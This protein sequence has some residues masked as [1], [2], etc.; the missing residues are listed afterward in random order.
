MRRATTWTLAAAVAVAVIGIAIHAL[1]TE[2]PYGQ[3]LGVPVFK[4]IVPLAPGHTGCE[5]PVALAEDTQRVEFNPGTPHGEPGPAIDVTLRAAGTPRVLARGRLAGGFDPRLPQF[6]SVAPAVAQNTVVDV[7]FRNAA[8]RGTALL[9]GSDAT[10]F[11]RAG[12]SAPRT[13]ADHASV[14]GRR[15]SGNVAVVFPYVHPRSEASLLPRMLERASLW[16]PA[17]IG[18]GV[19]WALLAVL[20][21]A[22]PV[23]LTRA[24]LSACRSDGT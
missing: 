1:T 3:T 22:C 9:F 12:G 21:L 10:T 16:R 17:W 2:R 13:A 19:Y 8:R 24:L 5:G 14:D 7:C 18:P 20:V 11:F 4:P 23:L 6:A 15:V